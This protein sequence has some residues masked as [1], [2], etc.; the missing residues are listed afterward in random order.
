MRTL[1]LIALVSLAVAGIGLHG[2]T[3][4]PADWPQWRGPNRDGSAG[5]FN[6]PAAWPEQLTR[7]WKTEVGLG[8][9]TP[10]LVGNRIY[11]FSRQGENETMSALDAAS[12]A[13]RW[14]TGYP[15]TFTMNNATARHGPGPKSTPVFASGKLFSIGM[16]GAVSAF[17]AATGKLLWQK[18]GSPIV[19]TFTTH[20]FS[21]VVEGNLAIFHVGG[22][23]QGALTAFDVNT[24]DVKWSWNG[25]GPSYGSPIVATIDGARQ[26]ITLTQGKLIGVE[27][28]TGALL[29]E[30]AFVSNNNTNSATPILF[31]RTIIASNGGPVVAVTVSKRNNQWVVENAWENADTP[32]RLSNSV[33]AGDLLFGLSTRNS[34]QYFAVDVKSGQTLWTSEPRQAGNAAIAR[35]GELL[36]SLEDDAE[37]V[38]VRASR[39]AF[40]VLKRY[41]V[42]DS[43]TWA[44]ASYSGNRVFVKDESTVALWTVNP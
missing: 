19:P 32:F 20:A 29:W 35:A 8:Y 24:G 17:D 12:G 4:S 38:V 7:K 21:P 13:V 31:G 30:R 26:V 23:N 27:V 42:A 10:V 16:T 28:A 18:P 15:A 34:G 25:D 36:F 6:A 33:L 43:S 37:L 39:T 3:R 9:A 40:E 5:S 14:K 41:T 1:K 11:M 2:Q 44:Q 22:H